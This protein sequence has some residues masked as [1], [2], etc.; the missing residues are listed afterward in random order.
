MFAY[1]NITY[2]ISGDKVY[3]SKE[4]KVNSNQG[5]KKNKITGVVLDSSG[6]TIIGANVFIKGTQDGVITDADGWFTIS[7]APGDVLTV[8][9]IGYKP[10]D[11]KV[12]TKENLRIVLEE[13]TKKLDE[14]VIVGYGQQKKESVVVA[15]SSVK[16]S[17]IATPTRNLTNSLAGQVSGL[18]AV[19]RSG[20]P[21][22][23]DAEFWIRGVSTFAGG[24]KPL[25]LVDG[26]PRKMN[27]IEPDE[28][29][30]F[31]V[32]KDDSATAVYGAEGA[33]GVILITTKRGKNEKAKITFKTE[34][35]IST[36]T[37]LP[38]FVGAADYL[39]LFNEALSNDG[40]LPMFTDEQIQNYRLGVDKDLYPDTDWIGELLKK[41][42]SNHRYTLNVRGGTEKAK[43]F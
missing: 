13:D 2:K 31:S 10:E 8:T 7:A 18:I 6:E 36:P 23:D 32:L 22:Y 29:E 25:V 30:T 28:I 27:D 26:V 15:M 16:P 35:S 40:E 19:Q 17:E 42:T 9:Y 11:V 43:Y 34:H 4:T 3:L 39:E 1:T 24:T 37:R 21:G 12:G 20:E 14:V 33:N 5:T 38:E 41:R